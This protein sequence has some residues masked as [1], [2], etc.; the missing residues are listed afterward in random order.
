MKLGENVGKLKELSVNFD[1]KSNYEISFTT[2]CRS[3]IRHVETL[4][5]ILENFSLLCHVINS[6][7]VE[8]VN[9]DFSSFYMPN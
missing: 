6:T 4:D 5:K 8:L 1:F 7:S 3:L 9:Y 2:F